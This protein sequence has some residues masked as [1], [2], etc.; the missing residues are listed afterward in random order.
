MVARRFYY[1]TAV[2]F[3]A[4]GLCTDMSMFGAVDYS[5]TGAIKG[6]CC[7]RASKVLSA[8]CQYLGLDSI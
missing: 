1:V 4:L 8:S 7:F 2:F 6:V 5:T 3:Y